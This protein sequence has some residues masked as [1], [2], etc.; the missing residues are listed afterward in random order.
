MFKNLTKQTMTSYIENPLVF[1]IS[2]FIITPRS[3]ASKQ[4]H[5]QALPI[6]TQGA[7]EILLPQIIRTYVARN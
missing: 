1:E 2:Q 4:K 7:M 5:E 6:E 3:S